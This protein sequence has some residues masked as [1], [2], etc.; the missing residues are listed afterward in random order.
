MSAVNASPPQADR[1]ADP[2]AL[3]QELL[4]AQEEAELTL[5][6]L[7]L[8]QEELELYFLKAEE[9][10]DSLK[11]SQADRDNALGERDKAFGERDRLKSD[12]ETLKAERDQVRQEL[13]QANKQK[14]E[15]QKAAEAAQRDREK[16]LGERDKALQQIEENAQLLQTAQRMLDGQAR[17]LEDLGLKEERADQA[18]DLLRLLEGEI[19]YYIGHTKPIA[20]MNPERV[21]RLVEIAKRPTSTRR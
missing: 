2:D 20:A 16:A 1:A 21:Q 18:L 9:L 5:E 11:T 12:V 10:S 14:G 4:S 6:Q 3:R 19:R 7:H 8:V 13:E 15:K 17:Y